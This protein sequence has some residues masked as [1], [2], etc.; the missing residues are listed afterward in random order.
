MR[1]PVASCTS[2]CITSTSTSAIF[3]AFRGKHPTVLEIGV[4]HGGSLQMWRDYFGRG[5]TIIGLDIDERLRS[6]E[7]PGFR[8]VIG[9]QSDPVFL[10]SLADQYGP[11][12]IVIDDGSH[13]PA[14]QVASLTALWPHVKV[15]GVYLVE[16]LHT[17]Y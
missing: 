8:V 13:A 17:S 1:S 5:S 10:K 7:D 2:G 11:F 6:L 16:D 12:D 9:D 15:G 3:D 14:H 4:S